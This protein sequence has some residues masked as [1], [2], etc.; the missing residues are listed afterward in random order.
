MKKIL[1][2]VSIFTM[3]ILLNTKVHADVIDI[4]DFNIEESFGVLETEK[5]KEF[6]FSKLLDFIKNGKI[7]EA[8]K[9]ITNGIYNS[10]VGEVLTV[11]N[12]LMNLIIIILISAFFT[13]FSGVFSKDNVSDTGFYICYLIVISFIVSLFN[14]FVDITVEYIFFLL[15]FVAAIIPTYM[16]SI[17]LFNHATAIGFYELIIIIIG[18]VQFLFVQ[19]IIPL[20]KIYLAISLVNNIAKED[21]LS[22]TTTLIKRVIHFLNKGL[23]GIVMGISIV[24]NMV[25][26]SVDSTKNNVIKKII[27]SL[28]VVGDGTE[29]MSSV[30]MGSANLIKNTIGVTAIVIVFVICS[31]P[32][33]KLLLFSASSQLV[34]AVV[35]PVADGRIVKGLNV[36]GDSINMLLKI[37]V[38]NGLLFIIAIAIVCTFTSK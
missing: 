35:Q 4:K 21:L 34:S 28:P 22:S 36:F 7:I 9:Y 12:V 14:N 20:I 11:E 33:I 27:G 30:L 17:A 37:I 29:A 31:I 38:Y 26:T 8:F 23:F 15:N 10:T 2:I 18:I 16:L 24:Q 13:N 5:F 3:I 19:V 32:Y 1:I 6:D 25:L